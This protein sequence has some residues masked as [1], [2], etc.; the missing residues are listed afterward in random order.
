MNLLPQ[1]RE[2]L[3]ALLCLIFGGFLIVKFCLDQ[4]EKPSISSDM[5]DPWKFLVT[6]YLTPRPQYLIGFAIYCGAML[7]I[8]LVVSLL[9][10]PILDVLKAVTSAATGDMQNPRAAPSET[11]LQNYPTFPLVVAFA[12]VG[13]NPILPKALDFEIFIRR[14]GHRIAYIPKNVDKIFNFMRFSEFDLSDQKLQHA[15][16]A[17]DLR[18]MPLDAPDLKSLA[19][20]INRAVMLYARAGMLA[21]DITLDGA[22][23]LPQNVS[24]EVFKQYRGEIQNVG[25]N[26]QAI[27]SRLAELAGAS[28]GDRRRLLQTVQRELIKNLELLYAVFASATTMKGIERISDRLRAIG[29][30]SAYPPAPGIPWNPLLKV[31]GAAAL[32]ML[33][34][35][36]I[37]MVTPFV[38]REKALSL[39]PTSP[40]TIAYLLGTIVVVDLVAIW[41]ALATR[42]RL[43]G[44]DEYFYEAGQG[45]AVA[46][47]WIFVRCAIAAFLLYVMLYLPNLISALSSPPAPAE[48]GAPSSSDF[49]VQFLQSRLS[50]VLIPATCGVM[51][52]YTLDRPTDRPYD[53][54]TSGLLQGAAMGAAA[55]IVVQLTVSN[56]SLGYHAFMVVLYGGLG[57]VLGFLLPAAIRRH[58]HVQEARLPEKISVLRTAVLQYFRDIQEFM[59]W[60]N[61]RNARLDGKRPLDMLTEESGLEK[62]TTLVTETRTKVAP[63]I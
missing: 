54:L 40:A 50:A 51:T 28:P 29:F 37:A 61:A 31:M 34:A 57:F 63:A 14:L 19:P 30:T 26:L 1:G 25:V 23:G 38:E 6:R 45:S 48:A 15:W 53:R 13:I 2:L 18:R 35:C 56:A 5:N 60:L 7:S 10:G 21:G 44:R 46:Y 39:V 11:T 62:L 12:I 20:V 32:V 9:P 55:L 47:L 8:F 43:I 42:A 17:A 22:T 58:W 24:L 59:E 4:F 52:A 49:V 41:Q 33:V 27:N 3:V 36:I 16:E